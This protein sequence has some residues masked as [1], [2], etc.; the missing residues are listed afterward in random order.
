M[1]VNKT[2]LGLQRE[3]RENKQINKNG[4]KTICFAAIRKP[5]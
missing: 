2:T 1:I 3:K 5:L 4:L